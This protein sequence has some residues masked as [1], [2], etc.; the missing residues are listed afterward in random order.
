MSS[1]GTSVQHSILQEGSLHCCIP[2]LYQQIGHR[3]LID[4]SGSLMRLPYRLLALVHTL[5]VQTI[6]AD[7]TSASFNASLL[8]G[9]YRPNLYL[10]IRPRIPDGIVTGLMWGKFEDVE[11]SG[12]QTL[13]THCY[14]DQVDSTATQRKHQRWSDKV[15][16]VCI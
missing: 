4:A 14:A 7:N 12:C 1:P 2:S 13:Q 9:P 3:T 10:G 8:W 16:M 6:A 15:W 5:L 11:R